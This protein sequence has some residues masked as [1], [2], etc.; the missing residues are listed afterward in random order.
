MSVVTRGGQCGEVN[1]NL[2][3]GIDVP[4]AIVYARWKW[5]TREMFIRGF[6]VRNDLERIM[7][8]LREWVP[9][10]QIYDLAVKVG[11]LIDNGH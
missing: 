5:L 11:S 1:W 7:W 2:I 10:S 4:G 9:N 8:G 6:E 3:G